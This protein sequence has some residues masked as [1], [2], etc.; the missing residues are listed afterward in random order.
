MLR[1]FPYHPSS[2]YL[3]L[4]MM[5]QGTLTAPIHLH[6]GAF[7]HGVSS[8]LA[9][10]AEVTGPSKPREVS[11]IGLCVSAPT[12]ARHFRGEPVCTTRHPTRHP[13]H[14]LSVSGSGRGHICSQTKRGTFLPA[15]GN[16]C[17]GCRRVGAMVTESGSKPFRY[18]LRGHVI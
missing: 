9:D 1:S 2:T 6:K 13:Q 4:Y 8:A 16:S 15:A 7:Q 3:L 12:E 18:N 10:Y 5:L 14:P 11:V 17:T